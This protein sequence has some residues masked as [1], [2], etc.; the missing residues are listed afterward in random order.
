MKKLIEKIKKSWLIKRTTTIIF[1]LAI[2]ALFIILTLWINKLNLDPIDFTTEKLYTLTDTSKEQVKDIQND[3]NIYFIGYSEES[4]IIDLA[5]QYHNVNEKIKIEVANSTDRPDL[6]EKYG[7][8]TNSNGVIVECGSKSKILSS[9]DFYTYDPGSYEQI[10]ITEEKLTNAIRYVVAEKIPTIYFLEGYSE[11]LV[12]QNM[13]YLTTYLGN[14]VTNYDTL[15]ILTTAKVPENCDT[16]VITSPNKDFDDVATNAIIEYINNGGNILWF[17]LLVT[18]EQNYTNVNKILAMYGLNPFNIGVIRETDASKMMSGSPNVIIPNI[19]STN[20]TKNIPAALLVNATKLNFVTDEEMEK[21]NVT[22]VELL[23]TGEGSY[24]RTNFNISTD[25]KQSGE[26]EGPFTIGAE[27][28]KKVAEANEE[29]NQKEK[30][31]KLVIYGENLFISDYSLSQSSAYPIISYSYNKDLVM[32]S[33]AYLVDRQEDIVVRKDTN[34]VN[35]TATVEQDNI[36]Q[37]IIFGVPV[38]I[39]FVG[40]IVWQYRRRKK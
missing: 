22:K 2:V 10:D 15:N 30:I 35:Y 13:N 23:Q 19:N 11:F 6:V 9:Y 1:M 29:T 5:K 36:I 33:I 4:S 34:K 21:L 38:L 16:L 24:Y 31:S 18:E 25:S 32:D 37:G 27:L 14:E 12:S 28:Q 39:I 7:I 8:D 3:V 40:I 20:I 26:E 17:N